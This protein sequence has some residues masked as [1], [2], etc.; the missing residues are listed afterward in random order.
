MIKNYIDAQKE[1][2]NSNLKLLE[3]FRKNYINEVKLGEKEL[4]QLF[5]III[6]RV[7]NAINLKNMTEDSIKK[8]MPKRI[9]S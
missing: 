2:E 5:S 3:L 8:Y 1:F 4:T 6:P 9:D 7:K